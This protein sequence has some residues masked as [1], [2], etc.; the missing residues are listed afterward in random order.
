MKETFEIL[1]ATTGTAD[2][3]EPVLRSVPDWFGIEEANR[4][5]LEAIERLPTVR[6]VEGA[7]TIG[8]VSIEQ[9]FESSFELHVLA[10]RRDRHRRGV[11][12]AMLAAAEAWVASRGGGFLQVKTL[13]ASANC[14]H[15]DR[16]SRWYEAM[17]FVPQTE[18]PTLWDEH[19]PCLQM[20]KAVQST[21]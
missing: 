20:I 3:C 4:A 10:V 17:G 5:Y 21:S 13:S 7:E 11:G 2:A 12:R 18:F 15:Y 6:A 9:H 14:E 19:N 8:F 16:T 1:E